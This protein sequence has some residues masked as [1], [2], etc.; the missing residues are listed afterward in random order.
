MKQQIIAK[1]YAHALLQLGEAS[2]VELIDEL[3][4][5]TEIINSSNSLE[6][7]LF[8]D[9]F[10][11]DEKKNVCTDIAKKA[12][13]SPMLVQAVLY[14]IEE[15]RIQLLPLIIKEAVVLDDDKK[16]FMKGNVEGYEADIDPTLMKQLKKFLSAKLGKEPQLVYHQNTNIT[17]GHRVT[18][19]DLQLD[20]SLDLKLEQFKQSIITE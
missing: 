7:V 15:R 20:A 19:E 17:A 10:T 1:T 3:I 2:K 13:F 6:N 11:A 8:L 12:A 16:G 18:I 4:K 9:V 5:L 14:L